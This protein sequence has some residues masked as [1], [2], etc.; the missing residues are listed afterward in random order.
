M[1]S[2]MVVYVVTNKVNNK[3]Y[4][5]MTIRGLEARKAQHLSDARN[6]SEGHFH[7]A[8]RKYGEDSFEWEVV[9]A[10]SS[11]S[12]LFEKEIEL[13]QKLDAYK[14]GYN[15]TIGGECGNGAYGESHSNAVITEEQALRIGWLI[16]NTTMTYLKIA[17]EV[18]CNLGNVKDIARG[19]TWAYL[20]L[21]PPYLN[22]PE[23]AITRIDGDKAQEIIDMLHSTTSSYR[24]IAL[25][26]GTTER[27]VEAIANGQSFTHL[28]EKAPRFNRPNGARGGH[29]QMDEEK[30]KLIIE[31]IYNTNKTYQQIAL[32][33][34]TTKGSV[35]HIA[36][37][38]SWKH[39]YSTTPAKVRKLRKKKKG[40]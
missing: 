33:F 12:E 5:G 29:K 31:E 22:R 39:L 10:G 23:G 19:R 2:K 3:K 37:G 7:R 6:G 36:Q 24:E 30:A 1:E 32:E 14:N 4:V 11:E 34:G 20:F 21:T 28:Y 18:G 40:R 26:C 25:I 35:N 16:E 27:V 9:Y 17:H 38:K 15:M 8:I 13:I